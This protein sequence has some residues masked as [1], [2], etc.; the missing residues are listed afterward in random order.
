MQSQVFTQRIVASQPACGLRAAPQMAAPLRAS[1]IER[2]G[3]LTGMRSQVEIPCLLEIAKLNFSV[4]CMGIGA[5]LHKLH[6]HFI[7]FW[8]PHMPLHLASTKG[9]RNGGNT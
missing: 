2:A 3:S 1:I 6:I 4:S 5:P 8:Q 7:K 9:G